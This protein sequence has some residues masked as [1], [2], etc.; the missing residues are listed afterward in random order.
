MVV[1][2]ACASS[3]AYAKW[4]DAYL[5]AALGGHAVRTLAGSGVAVVFMTWAEWLRTRGRQGRAG[6]TPCD[7]RAPQPLAYGDWAHPCRTMYAPLTRPHVVPCRMLTVRHP[8]EQGGWAERAALPE[9]H[10]SLGRTQ[11]G[12]ARTPTARPPAF[13]PSGA[14]RCA[15]RLRRRCARGQH[16]RQQR[17]VPMASVW[18]MLYIACMLYTACAG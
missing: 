15:A 11:E 6:L 12:L 1:K 17:C 4:T 10:A 2:G 3:G 14:P 9:L 18:R 16:A 13:P 5:V 8:R 7:I